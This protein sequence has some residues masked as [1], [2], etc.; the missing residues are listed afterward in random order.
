MNS[1]TAI[2]PKAR[3]ATF[4]FTLRK[5]LLLIVLLSAWLGWLRLEWVRAPNASP[6]LGPLWIVWYN[7]DASG[8]VLAAILTP[9]MFAFAFKP[10][11]VSF[12]VS[13]L[14]LLAWMFLGFVGEGIGC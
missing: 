4:Q 1:Q 12:V 14:G 2:G 11:P 7:H 13:M 5:A 3:A 9:C 6:L 10:H 8:V